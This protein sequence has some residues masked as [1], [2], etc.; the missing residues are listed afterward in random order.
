MQYQAPR[1]TQDLLPGEVEKW[2]FLEDTFRTLSSLYGYR[3]IRTPLFEQTELFIRS[4]GEDSDIVSK[5]MY[6]FK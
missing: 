3:E 4:V 6:T 1:G 5:E 2:Q